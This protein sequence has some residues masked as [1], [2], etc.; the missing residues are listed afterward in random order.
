MSSL[1]LPSLLHNPFPQQPI[2][3]SDSP[4]LMCELQ[5]A[6]LG[7]NDFLPVPWQHWPAHPEH[8]VV[9]AVS[10]YPKY[11][12]VSCS[13]DHS[14]RHCQNKSVASGTCIILF[15][16]ETKI[17][18]CHRTVALAAKSYASPQLVTPIYT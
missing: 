18:L 2:F 7:D 12:S 13:Q 17:Y 16:F 4:V 3:L 11:L 14:H 1:S 10:L 9:T 6:Q 8:G 5:T 15:S